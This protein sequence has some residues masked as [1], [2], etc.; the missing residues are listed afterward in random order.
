MN[1]IGGTVKNGQIVLDHPS[2]LPE[3]CRVVVKPVADEDTFGVREEDW[4][5]TPEAVT[6]WLGWYDALEPLRMTP[7]EEAAW[8]AARQAQREFEKARFSERAEK[9]RRLWE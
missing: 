3:G 6:A 4:L 7:E 1:A 2:D 5:D 9:V 8:Q